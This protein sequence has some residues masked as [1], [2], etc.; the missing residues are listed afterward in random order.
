MKSAIE[1]STRSKKSS[2]FK[3]NSHPICIKPLLLIQKKHH[4]Q[5]ALSKQ[6]QTATYKELTKAVGLVGASSIAGSV[7]YAKVNAEGR[8]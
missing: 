1:A 7:L 5:A 3:K 8:T 2:F 4:T 6:N